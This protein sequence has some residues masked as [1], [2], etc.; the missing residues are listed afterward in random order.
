MH[1]SCRGIST[2]ST[3][4]GRAGKVEGVEREVAG[5]LLGRTG[6]ITGGEKKWR[7]RYGK[8]S[9][10]P[11]ADH[12]FSCIVREGEAGVQSREI[13]VERT[14]DHTKKDSGLTGAPLLSLV[15][16]RL[17]TP[18]ARYR[19]RRHDCPER[20]KALKRRG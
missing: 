4:A 20:L 15:N 9:T 6:D 7:R 3:G 14:L 2:R 11:R 5:A 13:S 17:C 12:I 10:W 19:C 1:T 18:R 16:A 8:V